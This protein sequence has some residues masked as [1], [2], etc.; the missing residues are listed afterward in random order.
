[1]KS[2]IHLVSKYSQIRVLTIVIIMAMFCIITACHAKPR[3]YKFVPYK[4]KVVSFYTEKYMYG[5]IHYQRVHLDNKTRLTANGFSSVIQGEKTRL[6]D[7]IAV[8]DSIVRDT[9][10]VIIVYREGS[11]TYTFTHNPGDN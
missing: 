10:G 3:Q 4:G 8:G 5:G 1:M 2:I 7:Y 6:I 9:W 11:E